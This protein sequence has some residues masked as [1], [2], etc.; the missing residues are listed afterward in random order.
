MK[1]ED[2]IVVIDQVLA[3]LN[4]Y[5]HFYIADA[6]GLTVDLTSDIRRACFKKEI[7]LLVVKNT[8]LK[9]A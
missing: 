7:K 4:E 2:K 6:A 5:S 3:N 9:K 8:M 1:K